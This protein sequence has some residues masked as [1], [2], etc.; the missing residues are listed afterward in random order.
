MSPNVELKVSQNTARRSGERGTAALEFGL[1]VLPMLGMMFGLVVIGFDLGQDV[2]VAQLARSADAMFSRGVPMYSTSAQ[3]YLIQ[4][5][6][7]MNLQAGAGNGNGLI[8]L[9]EIQSVPIPNCS[10]PCTQ[11]NNVLVQRI[12][13]GNTSITAGATRFPTAGTVTYDSLDQVDNYTTDP[14]A[15]VPNFS[16][17]LQLQPLAT[18]YVAEAYF[19][20]NAIS[21]GSIESTPG[22][23]AQSFF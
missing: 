3:N 16:S 19:Q 22:I 17:S 10:S 2:Q 13:I 12:V 8:T 4:L 18:S 15:I 20:T 5:G 21:F 7:N 6:Q 23:Y 11:Y 14:N 1:I 9:S